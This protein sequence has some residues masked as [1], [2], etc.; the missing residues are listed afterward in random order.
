MFEENADDD[1][2]VDYTLKRLFAY[3]S[4]RSQT[5]SFLTSA[6][7]WW[8]AEIIM[9]S[10]YETHAKIWLICQSKPGDRQA[11]VEEFWGA[12]AELN[13]RKKAERA[14]QG[15]E[16]FKENSRPYEAAVYQTLGNSDLYDFHEGNRKER[17]ALEQ[18]WSFSE[19]LKTLE[20]NSDNS[21]PLNGVGA[22][23]H[24]YGQQSHLIHADENALDLM[25]D[26]RLRTP[27]EHELLVCSHVCRIFGDQAS[28]WTFSTSALRHRY[29]LTGDRKSH[30]WKL[31]KQLHELI[32]PV[33]QRFAD[34]QKEFYDSY[35][36]QD[37]SAS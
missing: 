31:W 14:K 30:R 11:L 16:V 2:Q 29:G 28:L 37:G 13:A 23:R 12:F 22:L 25:L 1:S 7:Y 21:F 36:S 9:R 17:K 20:E 27:E 26:R 8:D 18:K 19:I 33:S 6:N 34:S 5:I 3:Q 35:E 10:F 15:A 32:E 4:D 24:M